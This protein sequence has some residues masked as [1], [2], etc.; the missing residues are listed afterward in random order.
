MTEQGKIERAKI[1][2][3]VSVAPA[4]DERRNGPVIDSAKLPGDDGARTAIDRSAGGGRGGSV[5]TCCSSPHPGRRRDGHRLCRRQQCRTLYPGVPGRAGDGR[6]VF[7]VR[8]G[9]RHSAGRG[10]A[11]L[12]RWPRR[13]SM[14]LPKALSSPITTAASFMPMPPISISS[15]RRR[16]RHAAGGAGL[17]RR[18]RCV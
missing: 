4:V 9:L 14:A 1:E 13:S 3:P 8:A 7:A 16:Q 10:Q 5:A 17:H 11:G 6:R 18:C 15:M 2:Q 12:I